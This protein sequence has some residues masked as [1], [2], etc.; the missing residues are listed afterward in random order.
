MQTETTQQVTENSNHAFLK[1]VNEK[2]SKYCDPTIIH[3]IKCEEDNN[4]K[5]NPTIVHN[6]NCEDNSSCKDNL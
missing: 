4:C 3:N 5:C 6:I 2:K 1:V